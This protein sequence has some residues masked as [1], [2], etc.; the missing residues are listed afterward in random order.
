MKTFWIFHNI[1]DGQ[2]QEYSNIP[3]QIPGRRGQQNSAQDRVMLRCTYHQAD[4]TTGGDVTNIKEATVSC[5]APLVL[6]P[7]QLWQVDEGEQ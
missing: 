4:V 5:G 6:D 2:L 7:L 3:A 1:R